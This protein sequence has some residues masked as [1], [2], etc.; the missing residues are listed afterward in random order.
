MKKI[1]A[2]VLT[3]LMMWSI[4]IYAADVEQKVPY[5]PEGYTEEQWGSM[6]NEEQWD[7][8]YAQGAIRDIRSDEFVNYD[9]GSVQLM[10]MAQAG[11]LD[12]SKM[13]LIFYNLD[14]GNYYWVDTTDFDMPLITLPVGTYQLDFIQYDGKTNVNISAELD[15]ETFSITKD[16]VLDPDDGIFL[17][18]SAA[19]EEYRQ[20]LFMADIVSYSGFGNGTV[21]FD[22]VGQS[23][24]VSDTKDHTYHFVL[25]D[26]KMEDEKKIYAGDYRISN[27]SVLDAE[28]KSVSAYYDG[29]IIHVTRNTETVPQ[30][31]ICLYRTQSDLP[32]AFLQS[33]S[34]DKNTYVSTE[35]VKKFDELKEE[36]S[37]ETLEDTENRDALTSDKDNT[38]DG[39]KNSFEITL[40]GIVVVGV[41]IFLIIK[42][43]K[44][45]LKIIITF[46]Q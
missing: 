10:C 23:D 13:T 18:I 11:V 22:L 44:E 16:A 6:S 38:T 4:P 39:A 27:V 28:G 30:T 42:Y 32:S 34:D 20:N 29:G 12:C 19:Y 40:F 15:P 43:K 33:L 45:L 25:K 14:D 7:A 37:S 26:G 41:A 3:V 36:D 35:N 46:F 17:W 5:I 9:T 31:T 1:L 8:F 24:V 2:F 21:S